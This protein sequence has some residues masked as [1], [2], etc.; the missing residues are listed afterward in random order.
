MFRAML[1]YGEGMADE[2]AVCLEQTFHGFLST[3][4]P[5]D[6]T[7]VEARKGLNAMMKPLLHICLNATC[8]G[9]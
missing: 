4:F 5:Y 3:R 7:S 1:R 6:T 9:L 8:D 2:L